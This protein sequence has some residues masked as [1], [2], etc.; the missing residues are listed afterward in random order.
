MITQISC[1]CRVECSV[2][3][4]V[5]TFLGDPASWLPEPHQPVDGDWLVSAHA[6]PL[7]WTVRATVGE[8]HSPPEGHV[9]RLSW[10]PQVRA[11][12]RRFEPGLLPTLDG[13]LKLTEDVGDFPTLAFQGHYRAPGGTVGAT[14]DLG[15]MHRIADATL[16]RFV[17]DVAGRLACGTG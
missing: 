17:H 13:R 12:G 14:L 3:T 8:A 16:E 15:G 7:S 1:R 5:S 2:W 9:R 6:G 10:V 11:T 4:A